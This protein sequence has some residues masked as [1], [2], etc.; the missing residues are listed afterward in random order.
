MTDLCFRSALELATEIRA[1]RVGCRELL[2]LYLRR[3]ERY[4]GKL[5]AVIATVLDGAR[6]T[7]CR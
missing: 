2:D 3:I 6:C 5:N 7:A 4:N 1:K